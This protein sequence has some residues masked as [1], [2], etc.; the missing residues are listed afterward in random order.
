MTGAAAVGQTAGVHPARRSSRGRVLVVV[1]A[2]LGGVLAGCGDDGGGDGAAAPADRGAAVYAGSCAACHGADL[3]GTERG[4]SHLSQ[5]YEPGHHPDES[6]RRAIAQGVPAHHWSFGD[7][8]PVP[9]LDRADVD[10]VIAYVREQQATHG[11]EPYPP[12]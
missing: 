8:P 9:G 5:V 6:F 2:A 11:F 7:M 4:P 12:P 3:R 1:L 10:A